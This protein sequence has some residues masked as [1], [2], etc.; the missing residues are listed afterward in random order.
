MEDND[1]LGNLASVIKQLEEINILGEFANLDHYVEFGQKGSAFFVRL[2][3]AILFAAPEPERAVAVFYD[4][5]A[6][7]H[8]DEERG[9]DPSFSTLRE[10]L[11]SR[12]KHVQEQMER[13]GKGALSKAL[14]F[15]E[16]DGN[17]TEDSI[18]KSISSNAKILSFYEKDK[19]IIDS[20]HEGTGSIQYIATDGDIGDLP[21]GFISRQPP[22][23]PPTLS[24]S[25]I[26]TKYGGRGAPEFSPEITETPPKPNNVTHGSTS[27]D[28]TKEL[29]YGKRFQKAEDIRLS[30]KAIIL[31]PMGK[32]LVLKDAYSEYWDLPGG[33][34]QDDETLED[35][36][37]REVFEE[38]GLLVTS[39]KQLFTK[40]LPLGNPATK[41]PVVF[42]IASTVGKI[43]LSEEHT[44]AAWIDTKN[45]HVINLGV[46]MPVIIEALNIESADIP[47]E[48]V[49]GMEV[50]VIAPEG[51]E[52]A[53][54]QKYEDQMGGH[55]MEVTDL[56]QPYDTST[57]RVQEHMI[58]H[59]EPSAFDMGEPNSEA[60]NVQ[61]QRH[62]YGDSMPAPEGVN[63]TS[64]AHLTKN[65]P[66]QDAYD[67]AKSK[68]QEEQ[69]VV[70]MPVSSDEVID[71]SSGMQ[72]YTPSK[73]IPYTPDVEPF[74]KVTM[75][76]GSDKFFS[77]NEGSIVMMK[78]DTMI[79]TGA[80]YTE[81]GASKEEREE[82]YIEADH[83]ASVSHESRQGGGFFDSGA[84]IDLPED[85]DE[86][87]GVRREASGGVG[88]AGEG[89]GSHGTDG[90]IATGDTFVPTQ[91][92]DQKRS[93]HSDFNSTL[94]E[95]QH[96]QDVIGSSEGLSTLPTTDAYAEGKK[97]YTVTRQNYDQEIR[98]KNAPRPVRLP[99][100]QK[101]LGE[102]EMNIWLQDGETSPN[103]RTTEQGY[104]M[105]G[106]KSPGNFDEAAEQF[107]NL[108][109]DILSPLLKKSGDSLESLRNDFAVL[110]PDALK[111]S[112]VGKTLVVAGWGSYHVVD[113]E[114]HRI[115][116][117][118][119]R[120]ALVK[121]L[122]QSEYANMNIFHSGI[123]V[124]KI[125]PEFVDE[126]GKI[127]KTEVVD[128]GLFV[129]AEFRTDL[130]VSRR[131][132][133]EVL[134]GTLRG[135]SLAGNS[136]PETK[137][138][139]CDH[140]ECW[141]EIMDLEI[142]E[143]TLCQTPMN[144]DSWITDIVQKPTPEACPECYENSPTGGYD[145]SLRVR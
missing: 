13:L 65:D 24:Q 123:Q 14:S 53:E 126:A 108:S 93:Q 76:D 87:K 118:G 124:G 122:S 138:M 130:E 45:L 28:P 54:L 29:F 38:T 34:V 75:G 57:P 134:K 84:V 23:V 129:V 62:Q 68:F 136:N 66:L 101:P 30:T 143:I 64:L 89:T 105:D 115:S 90:P 96:D 70:R 21:P 91:G 22:K 133:G 135:F 46:F 44:D 111:K 119:L 42:F 7:I 128:E 59:H 3:G 131:A 109:A 6:K 56:G 141:E 20:S 102:G 12:N 139:L 47:T 50:P 144:Q 103:T 77:V 92:S 40:N 88:V 112:Q 31:D 36:L 51:R 67:T 127:W 55:E 63:V 71:T 142:Y 73:G 120:K 58:K 49:D 35:G 99:P 110:S 95:K 15:L 113:R 8:E 140:G 121:F 132:M 43:T 82:L 74:L 83:D 26:D 10:I 48:I 94:V 79:K 1:I 4:Q 114:G 80:A 81:G 11:V 17:D 60:D 107:T 16:F 137:Q 98:H 69:Q 9:A 39:S 33:H 85:M 72:Q 25:E 61:D 52:E 32:I 145:S 100:E 97:R 86:E 116:L 5:I 2:D 106:K 27:S 18:F 125:I 37:R 104:G 78:S 117:S 19:G 41:R